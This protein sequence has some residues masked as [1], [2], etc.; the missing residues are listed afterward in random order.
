MVR[1]LI[2]FVFIVASC[3]S[4]LK[5]VS[6]KANVNILRALLLFFIQLLLQ[7]ENSCFE[8]VHDVSVE[9]VSCNFITLLC[10]YGLVLLLISRPNSFLGVELSLK[11]QFRAPLP[12]EMAPRHRLVAEQPIFF[13]DVKRRSYS[14]FV[15]LKDFCQRC[16]LAPIFG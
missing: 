11:V 9:V 8:H 4:C 15:E 14:L 5:T 12:F 2:N 13:E 3:E 10:L 6:Y 1:M 16:Y 7:D